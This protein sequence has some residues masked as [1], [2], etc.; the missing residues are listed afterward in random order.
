M[1]SDGDKRQNDS[2]AWS[3]EGNGKRTFAILV[4]RRQGSVRPQAMSTL[5]RQEERHK[6]GLRILGFLK[7]V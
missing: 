1:V 3:T 6:G 5:T 4:Q 2:G 7:I